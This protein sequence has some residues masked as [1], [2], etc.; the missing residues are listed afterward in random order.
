MTTGSVSNQSAEGFQERKRGL[1]FLLKQSFASSPKIMNEFRLFEAEQN[2]FVNPDGFE[3]FARLKAE[4]SIKT[5]TEGL[6]FRYLMI[7]WKVPKNQASSTKE[8]VVALE[9]LFLYER[10]L[11]TLPDTS[12]QAE[13]AL[14]DSEK[15]LLLLLNLEDEARS[16]LQL[17]AGESFDGAKAAAIRCYER[18]VLLGQDFFKA[19]AMSSSFF[20]NHFGQQ[21]GDDRPKRDLSHVLCWKCNRK[22]HYARDCDHSSQPG[23]NPGT[24]RNGGKGKR[25]L[26]KGSPG[27]RI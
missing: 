4:Y 7:G 24:P 10:L 23:S 2:G 13:L 3:V 11:K 27:K 21:S 17:H 5:R 16:Y 14:P 26:G 19:P 6:Y 22:G 8:I 20:A 12:L 15:F 25:S 18:T 1:Y 9:S